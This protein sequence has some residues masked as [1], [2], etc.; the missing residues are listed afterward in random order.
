MLYVT[1]P[2]LVQEF[3]AKGD[4]EEGGPRTW[5]AFDFQ[6]QNQQVLATAS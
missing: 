2:S 4:L 5:A 6:G 1:G 3:T